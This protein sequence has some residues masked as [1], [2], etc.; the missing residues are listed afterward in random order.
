MTN[1]TRLVLVIVCVLAFF[2]LA[3]LITSCERIDAGHEGV[4]VNLYGSDKG[5]DE[6]AIVTGAVW[7]N[8][9]TAKIVEYATYVK[10]Y[11]Y[12]PFEVNAK[13]GPLFIVD[14]TISLNIKEGNS[15]HIFKKY[16][17]DLDEI[18]TVTIYNYVKDAFR[19]KMN[20]FTTDS[21]ISHRQRF[22]NAVQLTVDSLFASDGF[23]LQQLTSGLKY[24]RSIE[25]AI[26]QKSESIQQT[27][28]VENDLKRAEAEARIKLVQAEVDMKTNQMRNSTLTP[29][30]IQQEFIAKWDG[31]TPLYG[32]APTLFKSVE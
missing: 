18:A 7:Y 15:P 10:T 29:L 22:E 5:I 28:R 23:N 17:K 12:E 30:L 2:G 19:I 27:M 14:P 32:Q 25:D 26:N 13:D 1:K 16:R 4:R 9:F 6:V 31:R 21:L 3:T 20:E 24:P 11:D 8:P